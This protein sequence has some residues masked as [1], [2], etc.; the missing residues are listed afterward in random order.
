VVEVMRRGEVWVGNLNPT[1]G[2]EVG[3]IR[4]VLVIQ[5][6]ELTTSGAET[7]LILPM[8]TQV[9]P[10]MQRYRVTIRARDRLLK[11]CQVIVDKPRTLDR[12]RFG[13]GPLTAL[14]AEEMARVEK[15]FL[16]VCGMLHY[17]IPPV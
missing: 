16:A 2:G 17:A 9:R 15:S 8:T 14:T 10:N 6:D 7:V 13:D 1:R 5:A 4:P 3:K 12:K 11:D